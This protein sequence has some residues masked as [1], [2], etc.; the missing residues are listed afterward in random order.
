[1][2]ATGTQSSALQWPFSV[3]SCRSLATQLELSVPSSDPCSVLIYEQNLSLTTLVNIHRPSRYA[4]EGAD[5][6][7]P[8]SAPPA[9]TPPPS[10]P[11]QQATDSPMVD[12]NPPPNPPTEPPLRPFAV[13]DE[14][15]PGS[16]GEVDGLRLG[17]QLLRF[18]G[19]LAESPNMLQGVAAE[20]QGGVGRA[21]EVEVLRRGEKL[22]LGVTPRSW[23]GRGLLG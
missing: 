15:T 5:V 22:A 14:V 21:V 23:S 16:P 17:D 1:M 3:T 19:V 13:V 4:A 8:R 6:R 10:T 2:D 20:L 18:G 9:S 12:A 11:T 7:Q